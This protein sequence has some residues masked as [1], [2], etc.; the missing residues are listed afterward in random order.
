MSEEN[1]ILW[2][3]QHELETKPTFICYMYDAREGIDAKHTPADQM[4]YIHSYLF[5]PQFIKNHEN[6]ETCT[7]CCRKEKEE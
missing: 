4:K 7:F 2:C 1:D 3:E 5:H 6:C